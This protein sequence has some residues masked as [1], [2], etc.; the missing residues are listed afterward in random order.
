MEKKYWKSL[1]ERNGTPVN[2]PGK[3]DED[4]SK[5]LLELINEEI[6]EKPSSRRNF[7]K[8]AG[9]S[10]ATAAI[11]TSCKNPVNTAIPL[12]NKPEEVTPGMASFY[13]STYFDGQ[14]YGSILVKVRDG[15][16]IK[17]EGN[18]LSSINKGAS[19]A[20]IQGS[21]LSLYDDGGRFKAP[22]IGG[23]ET[24]WNM[25]DQEVTSKLNSAAGSGKQIVILTSTIISPATK[26]VIT[27]FTAKFPTCKVVTYDP[28]S[29][30]AMLQA[31][32]E[33]FGLKAIP[34]YHIEKADLI[35]SFAADFLGTWLSPVEFSR[36]WSETRKLS[37]EKKTI[38]KLQVFE[39]NMSLT[40]ANADT[41]TPVKPSQQASIILNLYNEIA[42]LK[43]NKTYSAPP[44]IVDVK[45][46]AKNLVAAEGKSLVL[47]GIN[48][49]ALQIIVNA[50][51]SMLGNYGTTIDLGATLNTRQGIDQEMETL[52]QD[53][54]SGAVGAILFYNSNPV[55]DYSNAAFREN[56]RNV[57]LTVCFAVASNE[58]SKLCSY[59]CPDHHYLESWNDAEPKKGIFSLQQPAI[60]NIFNT[61]QVQDS[62]LKWSGASV[63]YYTTLRNFWQ[64]NM[65]GK[66]SRYASFNDFWNHS[67]Q[68]GVF[69]LP[70]PEWSAPA[71]AI[72]SLDAAAAKAAKT[73]KAAAFELVFY[74]TIALGNGQHSNNPWMMEMPDPISKVCWDNFAAI[75]PKLAEKMGIENGDVIYFDA[76]RIEIPAFIQPGQADGTIGIA[77][78]YGRTDTGKVAD[79]V[80]LNVFPFMKVTEGNR[81]GWMPAGEFRALGNH[82]TLA[83][84]QMHHSM[85]GRPIV[86]ETTLEE[87]Q[88]RPDAGNELHAIH[89]EQHRTLYKDFEFAGHHWGMAIDLNA[90]TGCSSCVIACQA[91]NNVAV[92]GKEQVAMTRIMHWIRIDRYYSEDPENPSVYYQPIMCQQCDNAP[93]E[94]VCPVSATNHSNEGLNQMAYNRCI[95]T[96]YCINNCPYKVRRFNWFRYAT[97]DAFDYNQNS[98]LGRMVLNPDVTVRERG[99]VEKCSFCV[100]RIQEKKLLAKLEGR[101]LNDGEIMPA[102]MQACPSGAVVFGDLNDPES[103]VSKLFANQRNYHLLEEIHTLPSVGY[104]TKVR[105]RQAEEGAKEEHHA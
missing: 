14:D 96:K 94:N 37:D 73:P 92:V 33:S 99:V 101:K 61:R 79:G 29:A 83:T 24:T 15:R 30:S 52:V 5:S 90:C 76:E 6:S 46:L 82:Y 62:L 43:G 89:Q 87:W 88:A 58:T 12:L 56:L 54:Q 59:I 53:M 68:D 49:T 97:N 38:S 36:R 39:S 27:E 105:N 77:Y 55:Y 47:C 95:G 57:P 11:A 69:E 78:G 100:Q 32:T 50:I 28:A 8:F 86:R 64:S 35:V 16:P 84:T 45:P 3:H 75:S 63:D 48:D 17:I 71:L 20:R 34:D 72:A 7:L 51:N 42:A 66:Q 21:V 93:C 102:C 91:E 31:N 81:S 26:Q 85:E 40:G 22:M 74:E 80:G 70:A 1:E 25:I 103:R 41:R 10:F 67:L 23:K 19:S 65:A 60:R 104:L 9:F 2:N 98:D 4:A 18:E 44:S 13:A